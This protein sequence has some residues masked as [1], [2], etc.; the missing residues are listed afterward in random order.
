MSSSEKDKLIENL[1]AQFKFYKERSESGFAQAMDEY[2]CLLATNKALKEELQTVQ[3]YKYKLQ[4]QLTV[5]KTEHRVNMQRQLDILESTRKTVRKLQ[6]ECQSLE[7]S[8]RKGVQSVRLSPRCHD[9]TKQQ[10]T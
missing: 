5:I 10:T 1:E 6:S 9:A 3:R 2:S 8:Q 7:N 4:T